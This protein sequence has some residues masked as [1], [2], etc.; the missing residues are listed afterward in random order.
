MKIN[1]ILSLLLLLS[2]ALKAQQVT[3]SEPVSIRD[4]NSYQIISDE[5]GNVLLFRDKKTKFEVQGYDTQMRLSWEKEIELDRKN[6]EVLEVSP[7][8]GDFCVIYKFKQKLQPILKIHR[9]S[10]AANLLD[11]ATIKVYESAFFTPNFQV[12]FSEDKNI[13]LIWYV[14]NQNEIT[15]LAFD[16]AR[17]KVLWENIFIP[18]GIVMHRDFAQMLV[19]NSGDMFFVLKKDNFSS[20]RREHYLEIFDFGP[21]TNNA[22]RRYIVHMQENLTY[23][24]HFSFDNLNLELKAAGFY[25]TD[26]LSKAEGFYYLSIPQRKTD[27]QTVKFYP[28][29]DDFVAV[30]LEKDKGKNKGIPEVSVQEIVHRQDGGIILIGELNKEFQ[31]GVASTNYYNRNG[32]RPITDYYYDDVFLISIHPDGAMHWKTILHKKQYSQ[33]DDAAYSSYFLAKTPVALRVIFNDEIKQDNTVSEYVVR[34]TGEYDRRAVMSTER[35][36]LSLRFRDAVQVAANEIVIPSERRNRL[37]LVRV[38]Y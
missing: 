4:D 26:N 24:V 12:T 21:T 29:E 37:K 33:D 34:G 9:Y 13:A 7:L 38:S 17:M 35:K 1:L 3:V 6:P 10:S 11:S 14:E 28:F 15:A 8:N 18:E 5:R 36:D 19:N 16:I 31:R 27:D 2:I 23:D 22:L 25:A 32:F 30:L 20:K